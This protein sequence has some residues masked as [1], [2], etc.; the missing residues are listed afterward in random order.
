MPHSKTGV[1]AISFL[2]LAVAGCQSDRINPVPA[3]QPQ[4]LPAAPSGTITGSQLPPPAQPGMQPV[5]PDQAGTTLAA[6]DPA[7]QAAAAASAAPIEKNSLLGSW[8]VNSGGSSCQMFLTLTKYGNSS[9]GGTRGCS[10]ELAN[11]RA[12]DLSGNQ[13]VMYDENG[14]TIARLYSSGGGRLDGQTAGGTPVS[15]SR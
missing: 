1:F 14:N 8:S 11:M 13:V 9:R 6:V 5:T 7:A 10:N 3:R 4:P 15:V 2:A 12:W